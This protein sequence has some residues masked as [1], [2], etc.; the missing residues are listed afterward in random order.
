[1]NI[2]MLWFDNDK[3]AE[4]PAKIDKAAAFY[5]AKYGKAP[6]VVFV[7]PTQPDATHPTIGV[8]K[9]RSVMPNHFWVGVETE[10]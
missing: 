3:K 5:L 1:M 6:T 2:G 4:T 10:A 9:S 7:N 8:R